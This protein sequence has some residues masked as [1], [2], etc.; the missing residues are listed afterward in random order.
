[1]KITDGNTRTCFNQTINHY[2][3]IRLKTSTGKHKLFL[4]IMI[5]LLLNIVGQHIKSIFR[6][7]FTVYKLWGIQ[8]VSTILE[9]F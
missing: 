6:I 4:N 7:P 3:T 2:Y 8:G 9:G 5:I 1:M